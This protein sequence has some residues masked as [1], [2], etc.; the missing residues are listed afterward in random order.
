M[1]ILKLNNVKKNEGVIYY[2]RHYTAEVEIELPNCVEKIPIDF[3]IE[4]GPLGDKQLDIDFDP[5]RINYPFVPIK[6]ALKEYIL[7][8]DQL[9]VL[10]L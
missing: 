5:N 2:R 10:P 8:I 7:N 9:G 3:T 6:R 4:T 1:Q